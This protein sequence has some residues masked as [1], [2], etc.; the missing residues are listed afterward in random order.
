MS[1]QISSCRVG[2]DRVL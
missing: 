2:L 1:R